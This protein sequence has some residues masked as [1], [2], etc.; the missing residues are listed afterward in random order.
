MT[1][2]KVKKF[3]RQA[4]LLHDEFLVIK[5]RGKGKNKRYKVRR[6]RKEVDFVSFL[7]WLIFMS[8]LLY[9]LYWFF[10]CP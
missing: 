5:Q 8:G 7:I 4:N 3:A 6:R 10:L 2:K 9:G 1:T